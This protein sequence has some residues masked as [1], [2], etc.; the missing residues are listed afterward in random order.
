MPY[1]TSAQGPLGNVVYQVGGKSFV[2]F[3]N[4]RR[5]AKDPDTGELY[6]DVMVIW[7]A[8]ESD[9]F[10]LVQDPDSPFFTTDHF[11]GHPS[12]LVRASQLDRVTRSE[13]VELIQDAWLSQASK[14]R[15]A[16]WLAQHDSS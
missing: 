8:A 15:A 4:P 7:V 13:I 9:K 10:A 11:A 12:I 3:R 5:D 14:R 16:E 6:P 1:T 2:I